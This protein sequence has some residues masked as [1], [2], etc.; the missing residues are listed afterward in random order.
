MQK[1][2][3]LILSFLLLRPT[4]FLFSA[5]ESSSA[6]EILT[7]SWHK[8][9]FRLNLNQY[10]ET[11]AQ[12][13][14]S[15]LNNNYPKTKSIAKAALLSAAVPGAGEFYAGSFVKGIIFL[16]VEAAA[17]P[18][19]FHFHN[20]GE[21]LEAEF[22][23]FADQFWH[24][25]DYWL[26]L[27]QISG[28]DINDRDALREYERQNFSHFLPEEKNQQYYENIGK[29]DQFN[30]G[31]DDTQNG[32]ERDSALRERYTRMRKDAND[33]FKRATNM[34]TLVLFN[35][36]FSALDAGWTIKRHNKRIVSASLRMKNMQYGTEI[37]PALALRVK[38]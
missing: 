16:A 31:W 23:I 32:G 8:G 38:W 10:F 15:N 17:W 34:V 6:K 7:N 30:V 5:E 22:Q 20:R 3:I 27:S 13:I 33:N 36:V 14:T 9:T 12:N 21:D 11:R 19:Y 35:H 25:D 24:E 2:I 28:I 18:F 26:W 29:Y 1:P 37:I 4:A